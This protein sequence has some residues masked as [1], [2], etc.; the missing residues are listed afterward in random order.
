MIKTIFRSKTQ[1]GYSVESS[2][3]GV[4]LLINNRDN[5]YETCEI[6]EGD[7]ILFKTMFKLMKEE[8]SKSK[9]GG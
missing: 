6:K 5:E 4:T 9:N 1:S 8:K 3:D 7:V 2:N